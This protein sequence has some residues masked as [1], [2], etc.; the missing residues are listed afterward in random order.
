MKPNGM[1]R[2]LARMATIACVAVSASACASLKAI[3]NPPTNGPG[4]E[5]TSKPGNAP[6]PLSKPN[7]PSPTPPSPAALEPMRVWTFSYAPGTYT[8]NFTTSGTTAPVIDTTLVQSLPA[9]NQ[10]ATITISATGD[11]QVINPVTTQSPACSSNTTLT[12]LAQQL[13]PRIPNQIATRGTWRD[14]TTTSGCR[15]LVSIESTVISNYTVVGDTT[16]NNTTVLQ[17]NRTDSLSASGEGADGQHRVLI[18]AVGTGVGIVYLDTATG[19][20]AGLKEVQHALVSV[21]T[22]GRLA[23]FL[24]RATET[25]SIAN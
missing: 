2:V 1:T 11:V 6:T 17:I 15:G 22:S 18:A 4:S 9:L 7:P 8:Y 25:V 19:R 20:L 10:S 12:T 3:A 13:V 21:T 5:P 24:Q 14:S 23:R 16:I